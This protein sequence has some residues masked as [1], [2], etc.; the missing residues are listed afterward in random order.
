MQLIWVK[1]P[2]LPDVS[3]KP[4]IK[5]TRTEKSVGEKEI[6]STDGFGPKT[7]KIIGAWAA[8]YVETSSNQK[9]RYPVFQHTNYSQT[10]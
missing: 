9:T 1:S 3:Q 10:N 6:Q 8:L 5:E 4:K 2:T 7:N